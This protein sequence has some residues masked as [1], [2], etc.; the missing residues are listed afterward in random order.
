[1]NILFY[2]CRLVRHF[3][4]VRQMG[5]TRQKTAKKVLHRLA[6]ARAEQERR[7]A[8]ERT[9]QEWREAEERTEQERK[10]AEARAKRKAALDAEASSLKE[11]LANL[12]GLFS[13]K[14]RWEIEARLNAIQK[15]LESAD[16]SQNR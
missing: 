11:E 8:E 6:K 14:R 13:G 10:K 3:F 4:F 9:E 7:E 1:M 12:K 2:E 16:F 15:Q 5:G